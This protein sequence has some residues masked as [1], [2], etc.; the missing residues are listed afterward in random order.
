MSFCAQEA[1]FC[2]SLKSEGGSYKHLPVPY[3][4]QGQGKTD[5][6]KEKLDS[7]IFLLHLASDSFGTGVS[8]QN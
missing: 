3:P 6:Q 2:G 8:A 4:K 7:V 1:T 5:K